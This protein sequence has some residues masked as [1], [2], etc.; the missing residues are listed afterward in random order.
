MHTR[1]CAWQKFN[2]VS[3]DARCKATMWLA[4]LSLPRQ[5]TEVHTDMDGCDLELAWQINAIS[6]GQRGAQ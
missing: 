1:A 5:M 2:Q 3:M 4:D 6:L